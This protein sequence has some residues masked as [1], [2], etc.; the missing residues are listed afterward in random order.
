MKS[1][2]TLEKA[3]AQK[4][5]KLA[6]KRA[7]IVRM[8]A[9][10]EKAVAKCKEL[11]CEFKTEGFDWRSCS[12]DVYDAATRAENALNSIKNAEKEI[13][14]TSADLE[15]VQAELAEAQKEVA[16]LPE[17]LKVFQ[18]ELNTKLYEAFLEHREAV[19]KHVNALEASGEYSKLPWEETHRLSEEY[20]A[21]DEALARDAEF[22]ARDLVFS[23]FYR[24]RDICGEVTDYNNL[25][26]TRGSQGRAA[27]NG[28]LTG[29]RGK[30]EVRSI[31]AGG[32][33]IVCWHIRVLVLPAK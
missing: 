22:H 23:L 24:V 16:Q 32:Y 30:C 27:I 1:I 13:A 28:F 19:R 3:I 18:A 29:T 10:Y 26:I 21:T 33:N 5:E 7:T 12:N 14:K 11:G 15:K 17:V 25:K 8:Q 9:T 20:L 4:N 2:K 6:K 31:E